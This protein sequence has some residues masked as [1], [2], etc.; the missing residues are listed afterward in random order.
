MTTIE[1]ENRRVSSLDEQLP[2]TGKL[3]QTCHQKIL[4]C[5]DN[6]K[7]GVV[8][9]E[10]NCAGLKSDIILT[11]LAPFIMEFL[12]AKSLFML[13]ATCRT[14]RDHLQ[15]E[16]KR[17]K[18]RFAKIQQ[19]M[20][21]CVVGNHV[22][23][24]PSR[25]QVKQA[26]Q[27]D[28]EARNWIDSGIGKLGHQT[29]HCSYAICRVCSRDKW[30]QEEHLQIMPHRVADIV[31]CTTILPSILYCDS[32]V[33]ELGNNNTE[34]PAVSEDRVQRAEQ[35]AKKI[36]LLHE[37]M[38]WSAYSMRELCV[39]GY[40]WDPTRPEDIP[41]DDRLHELFLKMFS[42]HAIHIVTQDLE[43]FR[44]AARRFVLANHHHYHHHNALACF[45]YMLKLPNRL[46]GAVR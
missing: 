25:E 19:D 17:R 10:N 20:Q 27:L 15:Y 9:S 26:L 35:S 14:H 43:A 28:Q 44:I 30:F 38:K 23:H 5:H 39:D 3:L 12:D 36:W 31:Q 13:G 40:I 22:Q 46:G 21:A 6:Q 37:E 41:R 34:M 1:L 33:S 11:I 2:N 24:Q 32:L 16:V 7:D 18:Q 8:S 29:K 42:H 4:L 45:V